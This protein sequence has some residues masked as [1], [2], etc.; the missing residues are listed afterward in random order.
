MQHAA[1]RT[2]RNALAS[3]SGSIDFALRA[4]EIS[5]TR[6]SFFV[7][8]AFADDLHHGGAELDARAFEVDPRRALPRIVIVVVVEVRS[9][10]SEQ[11]A[12]GRGDR[13]DAL[14][15]DRLGT[16]TKPPSLLAP[17]LARSSP[18]AR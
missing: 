16:Y 1:A 3:P 17:A 8:P 6:A 4:V 11:L 9:S 2:D 15:F 12:T 18:P 5:R 13:V 10:L 14:S 7:A